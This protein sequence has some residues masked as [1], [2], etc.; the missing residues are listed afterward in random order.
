LKAF[1][2]DEELAKNILR[3]NVNNFDKALDILLEMQNNGQIPSDLLNLIDQSINAG[4]STSSLAGATS[5]DDSPNSSTKKLKTENDV[6]PEEE[7]AIFDDLRNDL[8]HLDENDEYLN[9]GTLE[10][11]QELIRQYKRALQ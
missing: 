3:S 11:E 8:I 7:K 4:A 10:N 1:G 6:S 5:Q 2:F 9:F